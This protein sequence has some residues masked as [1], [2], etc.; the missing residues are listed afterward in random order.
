MT[1]GIIHT[2]HENKSNV[3][4]GITNDPSVSGNDNI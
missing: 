1:G 2:V 3:V 4:S